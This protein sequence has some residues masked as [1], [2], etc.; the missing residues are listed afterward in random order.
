MTHDGWSSSINTGASLIQKERSVPGRQRFTTL[1]RR[2][3]RLPTRCLG[4]ESPMIKT[5]RLWGRLDF[6]LAGVATTSGVT[7]SGRVVFVAVAF[8]VG[9]AVVFTSLFGAVGLGGHELVGRGMGGRFSSGVS[10][11]PEQHTHC[12]LACQ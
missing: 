6:G 10:S 9:A 11:T 3:K 12:L 4:I 7:G 1:R 5:L 8:V 2:D